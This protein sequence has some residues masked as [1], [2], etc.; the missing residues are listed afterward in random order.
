MAGSL[1]EMTP[2]TSGLVAENA[3]NAGRI[4]RSATSSGRQALSSKIQQVVCLIKN[5]QDSVI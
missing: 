2:L 4:F 5:C 3:E 1:Q